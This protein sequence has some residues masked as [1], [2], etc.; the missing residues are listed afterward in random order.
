METL[1]IA[2]R[3]LIVFILALLFGIE[4]QR[5]HKPV[6]F[7]TF[8]FVALGSCALALTATSI[9]IDNRIIILGSIVTG[10]G[11]LGAGALIRNN[12]KIFGFTTAAS[13]WILAIF[14]LIIGVGQYLTGILVYIAV[15]IVIII[16][17]FLEDKGIG[18]YQRKMTVNT[19]K[20]INEK[21]ITSLINGSTRKKLIN[22]NLDKK[23]NKL[24]LTYLIAGKK[25]DINSI[26]QKLFDKPWFESFK[27]E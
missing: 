1:I 2:T 21:E 17:K 13:I 19:N 10:I 8:I 14:G 25:E 12:D 24:S 22:I 27:V 16:D 18:S 5:A 26:P 23:A 6:S 15:W 9:D 3:F 7:G 11:F 20:I 4:R